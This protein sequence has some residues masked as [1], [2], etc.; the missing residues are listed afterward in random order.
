MFFNFKATVARK[1]KDLIKE[2]VHDS[3]EMSWQEE[4]IAAKTIETYVKILNEETN[5]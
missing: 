3:G 4:L 1:L 5:I 2:V